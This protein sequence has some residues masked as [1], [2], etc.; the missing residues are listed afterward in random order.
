MI[1]VT[2]H[3]TALDIASCFSFS[4]SADQALT[5]LSLAHGAITLA[6]LHCGDYVVNSSRT[7]QMRILG[8]RLG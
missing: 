2:T 8:D 1:G 7:C 6:R 3:P 4:A 5:D